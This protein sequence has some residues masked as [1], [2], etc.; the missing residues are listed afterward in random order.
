MQQH[1]PLFMSQKIDSKRNAQS[2]TVSIQAAAT[3]STS[4]ATS[5]KTVHSPCCEIIHT[6]EAACQGACIEEE[7]AGENSYSQ[8]RLLDFEVSLVEFADADE[9][10]C[11]WWLAT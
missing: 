4:G 10:G 5:S 8:G 11:F 2:R 3:E 7:Q 1:I 6:Q 9:H